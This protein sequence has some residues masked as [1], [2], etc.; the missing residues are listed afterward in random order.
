[1]KGQFEVLFELED[2]NE[3]IA[4]YNSSANSDRGRAGITFKKYQKVMENLGDGLFYTERKLNETKNAALL[5]VLNEFHLKY[6]S[7]P[8][9][10]II[11][12][13]KPASVELLI[14]EMLRIGGFSNLQNMRQFCEA[15][16]INQQRQRN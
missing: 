2:G 6:K 15:A 16:R 8:F 14:L 13:A 3:K 5:R 9:C 1:M 11:S 4:R 12:A 7:K 10:N